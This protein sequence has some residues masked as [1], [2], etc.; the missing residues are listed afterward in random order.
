MSLGKEVQA[1]PEMEDYVVHDTLRKAA[2]DRGR[3]IMLGVLSLYARGFIL[4]LMV[5]FNPTAYLPEALLSEKLRQGRV[6]ELR[7]KRRACILEL[8]EKDD[9]CQLLREV[10]AAPSR[11]RAF[12][13]SMKAAEPYRDSD[14]HFG[15]RSL[16]DSYFHA[17][18]RGFQGPWNVMPKWDHVKTIRTTV[19]KLAD[20]DVALRRM[21]NFDALSTEL[22]EDVCIA[23]SIPVADRS[24]MIADVHQWLDV[25]KRF[26]DANGKYDAASCQARVALLGINEVAM[27]RAGGAKQRQSTTNL[28]YSCRGF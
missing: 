14:F 25:T 19:R 22:L 21:R 1:A 8:V 23:R 24:A 13:V 16:P 17:T 2:D 3:L 15:L 12:D 11:K 7:K 20:A 6:E 10:L 28:L 5:A 4:P 9:D 18:S 26:D 27:L